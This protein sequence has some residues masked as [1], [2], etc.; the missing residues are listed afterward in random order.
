VKKRGEQK[1]Y[2]VHHNSVRKNGF[3]PKR[4]QGLA[5]S[6][7]RLVMEKPKHCVKHYRQKSQENGKDWF[8]LQPV[9]RNDSVRTI[10]AAF[11]VVNFSE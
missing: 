3:P 6:I 1:G 11:R 4:V 2:F 5:F 8:F 10:F 7:R 9:Q